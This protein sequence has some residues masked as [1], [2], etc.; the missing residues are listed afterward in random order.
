MSFFVL[1]AHI[2]FDG[3]RLI[4]LLSI[5]LTIFKQ[6][7]ILAFQNMDKNTIMITCDIYIIKHDFLCIFKYK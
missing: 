7:T 1:S 6:T 3:S 5:H 2:L 4:S